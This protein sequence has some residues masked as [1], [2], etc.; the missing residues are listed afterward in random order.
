MATAF[1]RILLAY[2]GLSASR[3]A[4]DYACA[5]ARGGAKLTIAHAVDRTRVIATTATATGFAAYDP[6]PLIEALEDEGREL[7]RSVRDTCALHG[8]EAQ[9]DFLH[10][11]PGDGM[12]ELAKKVKPD[13]IIVG[14][15][16]RSGLPRTFFGSVAEAIMRASEVPV[17]VINAHAKPVASDHVFARALVALD[18]SDPSRSAMAIAAKIYLDI[19]TELTLCT[20]IA[21]DE[22]RN[23]AMIL[24]ESA[25]AKNSIFAGVDDLVVAL[26]K[27]AMQIEHIAMQRNCDLIIMGS[28]GRR[29]FERVRFGS[30]AEGVMR[31]SDLPVLVVPAVKNAALQH[32]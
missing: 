18:D 11:A 19:S 22:S 15:H 10:D 14:T 7:L 1:P 27:P 29:N 2:E 8:V 32:A 16:G 17:L 24:L 23:A 25:A 13:L 4:L 9:T 12:I 31:A 21:A 26:G 20:V 28:H 30:V 5:L 6:G 3:L